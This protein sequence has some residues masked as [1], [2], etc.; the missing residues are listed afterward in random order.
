MVVMTVEMMVAYW[1]YSMAG[2]SGHLLA[3]ETA[4]KKDN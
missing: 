3:E 1:E 4:V 2:Q